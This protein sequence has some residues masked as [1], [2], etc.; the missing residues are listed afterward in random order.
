MIDDWRNGMKTELDAPS[1]PTIIPARVC[2][3][4]RIFYSDNAPSD[5]QIFGIFWACY[6]WLFNR[7]WSGNWMVKALMPRFGCAKGSKR[8]TSRQPG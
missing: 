7:G 2:C 8:G 6:K 5:A 4:I 1:S 3:N